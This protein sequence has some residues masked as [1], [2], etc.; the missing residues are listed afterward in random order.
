MAKKDYSNL[1]FEIVTFQSE[2]VVTAS[3]GNNFASA[4]ESWLTQGGMGDEN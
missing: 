2:D 4:P 1:A 3:K